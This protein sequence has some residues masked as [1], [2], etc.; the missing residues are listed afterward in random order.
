MA[1]VANVVGMVVSIKHRLER[2]SNGP[3]G[4]NFGKL[5]FDFPEEK[6]C[7]AIYIVRMLM[8]DGCVYFPG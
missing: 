2:Q 7:E 1:H 8:L 3:N 4:D 5:F 6:D